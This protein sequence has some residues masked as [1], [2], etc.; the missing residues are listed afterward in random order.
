M[1]YL[2]NKNVCDY[3]GVIKRL[4]NSIEIK[5]DFIDWESKQTYIHLLEK[6]LSFE[7]DKLLHTVLINYLPKFQYQ[8]KHHEMR[9]KQ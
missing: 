5:D 2:M 8:A 1:D 4:L 3:H 6:P 9:L 7:D